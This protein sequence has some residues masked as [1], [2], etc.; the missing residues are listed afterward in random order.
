MQPQ[1][2]PGFSEIPCVQFEGDPSPMALARGIGYAFV[3]ERRDGEPAPVVDLRILQANERTLLAWLRTGLGL[4]AFGFLLARIGLW[5]SG[6][7]DAGTSGATVWIG[8]AFIL[9]GTI[10]NTASAVRFMRIRRAII[11]GE[12]IIPGQAGVLSF[13]FGLALLGVVLAGYVV[14]R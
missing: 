7:Q 5:L 14:L 9:L 3:V 12:A 1:K 8:A 2:R 6:T 10:C 4:M 11:A 13:A